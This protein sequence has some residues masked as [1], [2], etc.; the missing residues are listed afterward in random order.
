[1]ITI[2]GTL[3][4][5]S[6]NGRNGAFNVADLTT[7]IGEFKVKDAFLDQFE[8][9]AYEGAFQI[10]RI[11][12]A[13]YTYGGRITIETRA[14]ILGARLLNDDVGELPTEAVEPDPIEEQCKPPEAPTLPAPVAPDEQADE[15][16]AAGTGQGQDEQ[17]EQTEDDADKALFGHIYPLGGIVAL[18]PTVDRAQFR[19]Q[20]DRLK[21]LGYHF[22][23]LQQSWMKAA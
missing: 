14:H 6:I 16:A 10:G 20:R 19:R 12:S 21:A 22:D 7:E 23:P 8:E 9:G 3:R 11:F 18:D 13:S 4:V 17:D 1:M 15:Q 5:R 2:N